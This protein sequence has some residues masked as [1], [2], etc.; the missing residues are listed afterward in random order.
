MASIDQNIVNRVKKLTKPSN[1]AQ[2]LQPVFEAVSNAKFAID[3]LNERRSE[4]NRRNGRIDVEVG[5]L[6]DPTKVTVVVADDGIGLD[7]ARF[8][9]FCVVD[10]D[11]KSKK[12]GKG[13]GR[14]FWLDSF[15]NISVFSVFNGP[16]GIETRA[17][18]FVLSNEDQIIERDREADDALSLGTRIE[19]SEVRGDRYIQHFPKKRDTFLRYFSAHFI[20]D[21]LVGSGPDIF[22]NLNGDITAYPQAI[23]ELVVGEKVIIE[24]PQHDDFGVLT[25]ECFT[26]KEDASKGLDGM[27]QLHLLAD[28]RTVSTR[29]VD[30]LIGLRRLERNGVEDLVFHGCVSGEYLNDHVNEGRTA[31]TVD[32]KKL[33]AL[34]RLCIDAVKERFLPKQIE[35]YE[36]ARRADYQD[37]VSR[38]PIYGF[39]D[40]ETQLDRIPFGSR[41]PEEFAAGLIKHQIRNEETRRQSLEEIIELLSGEKNVPDNFDQTVVEAAKDLKKSEKLALAQHVVKRK[42]VLE[43]MERLILRV[44]KRGEKKEDFHLEKTLH[45]FICPMNVVGKRAESSSH[46]LW[47]VDERLAFT[48]SFA[49]DKRLDQ[50]LGDTDSDLRPDLFLW[51]QAFGLGVVGDQ[52]NGDDIDLSEPLSKIMIVEFKRPGRTSYPKPEDDVERQVV[53]YIKQLKGGQIEAF[54]RRRIRV[55]P[56]CRFFCYVVADIVGDLAD[57]QMVGWN[58]TAN[59]EGRIRSL[60]GELE[61]SSIEVVQWTE[62]INEAWSRNMAS[63]NAAGLR[64]GKSVV[65]SQK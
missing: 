53:K 17:F 58:H 1:A 51:D 23:S 12:G 4:S 60:G 33:K 34:S 57:E 46:D 20:A 65:D 47:V 37:F 49:S 9:A 15:K 59:G 63:I 8:D 21:F 54:D 18:D 61:G 19:F 44:R 30:K 55:A 27:H 64:R 16:D 43:V 50:V 32:E 31:F 2:A 7:K 5:K 11:F 42:L 29:E 38:Y 6:S 10:T 41:T 35:E 39:E 45:T 3:D 26:C 48:Q 56:D 24:T 25:I 14:L 36:K 40:E 52:S 28:D 62:L 13:V 22:V